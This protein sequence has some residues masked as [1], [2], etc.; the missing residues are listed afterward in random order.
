[1]DKEAELGHFCFIITVEYIHDFITDRIAF[2]LISV[3]KAL[4]PSKTCNESGSKKTKLFQAEKNYE[5]NLR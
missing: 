3:L 4:L 1:M 5:S 2:D